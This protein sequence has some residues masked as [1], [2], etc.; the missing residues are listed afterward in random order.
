LARFEVNGAPLPPQIITNVK[1]SC[2][3]TLTSL[4]VELLDENFII[5]KAIKKFMS[6]PTYQVELVTS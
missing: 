5:S 6:G 2:A 1:F 3:T 4:E